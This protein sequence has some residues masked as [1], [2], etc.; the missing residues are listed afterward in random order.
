MTDGLMNPATPTPAADLGEL[1]PSTAPR[2]APRPSA[3][4]NPRAR[5]Y[6]P[7]I[8]QREAAAARASGE[9]PPPAA[10]QQQPATAATG[11]KFKIGRFEVSEEELGT[12]MQ[13]QAAEDVRKGSLPATPEAYRA[14]LP[15]DFK[16]PA[17]V[18]FKFD[19]AN[20]ALG[21]LKNVAHKHGLTQDAVNELIGVYAGNEVGTEAA[22]AAARTA[23]QTKLGPAAPARI[24]GLM[25][26]M[27]GS[28]LGVLKSTVTTAAQVEAWES[29]ITKLTSQGGAQFSQQHRVA[30][31]DKSIPGYDNMSFEQRRQAQDQLAA[32]R[33]GR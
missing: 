32:R 6:S 3:P 11:E 1:G 15:A 19:P 21:Q 17:G 23:E 28:G 12:L 27:D 33:G 16:P 24:D 26:W 14:E 20:P 18:E 4:E 25:R 2:P 9:A 5:G 22:I 31:D 13:R 29:H 7:A 8:E 30:P 10:D